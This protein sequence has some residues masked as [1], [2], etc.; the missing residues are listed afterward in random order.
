MDLKM[1]KIFAFVSVIILV[2]SIN[3]FAADLRFKVTFINPG[4]ED[5]NAPSGPFWN[6]VAQFMKAAA[7]DLNIDLEVIY[8]ARN[9]I[10]MQNQ[11][12][13]VCKR[14][15]PPDY[16]VVVNEKKAADKI[17]QAADK[18]GIKVFVMMNVFTGKQK[19]EMKSPRE[20]YKNWIGT[21]IPDNQFAGYQIAKLTIIRALE[22]NV[23][24]DG[25]LHLVGIAGDA[26]TQASVERIVG[27]KQAVNEYPNIILKQ[28]FYGEWKKDVAEYKTA[29]ALKRY[30]QTSII[31]AANDPMALGAMKA[32]KA[33]GRQPGKDIFLGGLN[34][35][36]SG[37]EKVEDG[38]L[39]TSVGGH[40]MCGGWVAVLL[41]DHYHEIDFITEGLEMKHKIFGALHLGNIDIFLDK[42]RDR[43]W[44]KID[45]TRFSKKFNTNIDTYDF[46]LE[47]ILKQS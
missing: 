12:Y 7:E 45:F 11:A 39:V 26:S 15:N 18:A 33:L 17:V 14:K 47:A 24:H 1:K 36:S 20:K 21:L 13:E 42:F 30:P 35:D 37:L 32:V 44:H 46:S 29:I 22:A 27:L 8:S 19:A 4:P 25:K 31:W 5:V 40:F 10:L 2:C 34:W 23:A 41:H 43:N 16:L 28:I 9:H 6:S 38:S 3:A